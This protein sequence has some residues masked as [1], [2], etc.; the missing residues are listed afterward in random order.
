[1]KESMARRCDFCGVPFPA[2]KT[3]YK[4]IL[5]RDPKGKSLAFCC[6]GCAKAHEKISPWPSTPDD[7]TVS[8]QKSPFSGRA[9]KNPDP[10]PSGS[11]SMGPYHPLAEKAIEYGATRAIPIPARDVFIDPRAKMKCYVPICRRLGTN[12]CC[13]PFSPS[14]QET[15]QLRDSYEYALLIQCQGKPEEFTYESSQRGLQLRYYLRLN[16]IVSAVE[17]LAQKEG[18]YL[19]I[20][21]GGGHCKL[22]GQSIDP[23]IKCA[24]VMEGKPRWDRCRYPLRARPAM[25]S[26][27]IDVFKTARKAGLAVRFRG[28]T[29]P[30]QE[31][32]SP[33]TFGIVFID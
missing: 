15:L 6:L 1:M 25:E 13:P 7:S 30:L 4:P 23:K 10:P 20:G 27:G 19:A 11:P 33:S 17:S 9:L 12:L 32:P 28:I 26:V 21:F 3:P 16:N 8:E 29:S 22:C 24:G 31:V 5:Q 2:E 18:H 14:V